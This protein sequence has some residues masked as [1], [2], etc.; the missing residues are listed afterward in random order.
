[1]NYQHPSVSVCQRTVWTVVNA[2]I[3]MP[4]S[5]SQIKTF[6]TYERCHVIYDALDI[7]INEGG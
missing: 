7:K 2:A 4:V 5:Q 1:M 6:S 3:L